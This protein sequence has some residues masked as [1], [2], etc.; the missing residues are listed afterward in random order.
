[1]R[2][3]IIKANKGEASVHRNV[4]KKS[5]IIVRVPIK[6]REHLERLADNEQRSI[7]SYVRI[8]LEKHLE[9]T[10]HRSEQR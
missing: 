4:V 8:V 1:L 3:A 7:S 9:E 2:K 10:A 5:T 6:V